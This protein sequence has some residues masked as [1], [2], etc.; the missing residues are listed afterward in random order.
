VR[1]RSLG[2]AAIES[3]SLPI[4]R[5]VD[6][7][8]VLGYPIDFRVKASAPEWPPRWLNLD[9]PLWV[10]VAQWGLGAYERFLVDGEEE[11]REAALSAGRFLLE[12]QE[13]EG[14]RDGAWLHRTPFPHTFPL[15]APWISAMAQGEAASLLVRL[16][17]ETRDE[18]LAEA[19]LRAL[20]PLS[21]PS[22]AGGACALLDG[23]PFPEEYP[24]DPPSFVLNGAIFALWG[25][26]DVSTSLDDSDAARAFE[27]GVDTLAAAID[28]WDLGYW[29]RYDLFPHAAINIASPAYHELH[30]TQ[31]RAMDRVAPRSELAAAADRWAGYRADPAAR[32]R[33]LARKVVFRLVVPR[34]S[35]LARRLP[36]VPKPPA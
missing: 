22:S 16:Y 25:L 32:S 35:L 27:E 28:R 31:L 26:R 12:S 1:R 23:S 17:R 14:E 3:F 9:D 5:F 6:R 36:W 21:V 10:A 13:R 24:T 19:A 8:D 18:A 4:G 20:G 34:N 15:R 30:I 29:S 11:W 33:A 7:E 2:R